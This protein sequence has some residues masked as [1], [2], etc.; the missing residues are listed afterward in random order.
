MNAKVMSTNN[1]DLL[2]FHA[3]TQGLHSVWQS[4]VAYDIKPPQKLEEGFPK[5]LYNLTRWF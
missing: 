2:N 3:S 5:I 1:N 4:Q